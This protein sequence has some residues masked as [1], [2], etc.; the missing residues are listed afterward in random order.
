KPSAKV[1]SKSIFMENQP[2]KYAHRFLRWFCREDYLEEIEGNLIELFEVDHQNHPQKARRTFIWQVL[3]HFRPDF[4]KSFQLSPVMNTGLIKNYFKVTWRHLWQNKSYTAIN[5]GGLTLGFTCFLLISL[6]IQYEFSF[7]RHHVDADQIYRVA[8]QRKGN[9]FEGNDRYSVSPLP[10]GKA[11]EETFPE[12]EASTTFINYP[13]L[14]NTDDQGIVKRG[15]FTDQGFSN[16]FSVNV[17]EGQGIEALEDPS[18][19]LLSA[20]FADQLFTTTDPIGQ[21]VRLNNEKPLTVKGIFQDV[22]KNQQL[23]HDFILSV[24]N[25]FVYEEDIGHWSNNNYR[26]FV[27]LRDDASPK[28]V[29]AKLSQFNEVVDSYYD[30]GSI[31]ARFYLSPISDLHLKSDAN[32]ELGRTGDIQYVYLLAAIAFVVLL[33]ASINYMNLATAKSVKRAKEI[34]MRKVLGAKK[35]QL[36]RQ[37]LVESLLLTLISLVL[38]IGFT[39]YLLPWF[40]ELIGQPISLS[41][42]WGT[43]LFFLLLLIGLLIGI[44]SGSYP[45]FFLTQI[46]PKNAFSKSIFQYFGKRQPV[47]N[48]LIVL[49]FSAAIILGVGAF[50]INQ[51]LHF[52]QNKK[53]G[54]NKD[55][56]IYIRYRYDE[57]EAKKAVIKEQ[58]AQVAGVEKVAITSQVPLNTSNRGRAETWEGNPGEEEFPIYRYFVDEDF[59]DLFEI[60]LFEGRNFSPQIASDSLDTYILNEAAMK[61]AGWTTAVD[62]AFEEGK[63]IGVVKDFHFQPFSQAIAPLQIQY[64][65]YYNYPNNDGYFAVKIK[66]SNID[67]TIAG[68]K[69]VMKGVNPTIPFQYRFLD[70]SYQKLYDGELRLG[71]AFNYFTMIAIFIACLGLFGLVSY[72]TVRRTKE[73]GIRK[74]MGA[75]TTNIMYLL[76]QDFLKLVLIASVIA[77]PISWYAMQQWLQGFAYDVGVQWWVFV[78]TGLLVI[79]IAILTVSWQ[80]FRASVADPIESIRQG[81]E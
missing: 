69:A 7:D 27:K 41:L 11:M 57:I 64:R 75:S 50:T 9:F 20:S 36:I 18:T 12:V 77:I 40:G 68:V 22:P 62:K 59:M 65:S 8:M 76:S 25:F 13:N 63:V 55:Q 81:G 23:Q 66:E 34:G 74:V 31:P 70:E 26:T 48:L 54:Y 35:G 29:T 44:S 2:P 80:S 1:E 43:G 60:E 79:G 30:E 19:I 67:K 53:L 47:R 28:V 45:A 21:V 58:L 46:S 52:I 17:V 32:F 33:L 37:L 15:T 4:I 42:G 73:I 78:I 10:L 24:K 5:I 39:W 61:A 14:I 49:Q 72:A 51:Q 6:F 38:S 3:L 71:K 16:I 56:I